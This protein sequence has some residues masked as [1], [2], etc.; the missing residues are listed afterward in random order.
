MLWHFKILNRLTT[1]KV[2]FSN[3]NL[4]YLLLFKPPIIHKS[5]LNQIMSYDVKLVAPTAHF[6]SAPNSTQSFFR[7]F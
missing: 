6:K 2:N 1:L 3:L 5:T 4:D 7:T